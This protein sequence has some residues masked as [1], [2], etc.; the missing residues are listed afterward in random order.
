MDRDEA[1]STLSEL[2]FKGFLSAELNVDG[3]LMIFKTVNEKEFDLIKMY[4]GNP[5]G[6][7]YKARFNVFFLVFSAFILENENILYER[8]KNIPELYNYFLKIPD[9]LF[10]KILSSL[11]SVRFLA[12]ET[13]KFLEGFSYTTMSRNT[14]RALGVTLP[15][16]SSFTGI[17]GSSDLGLNVHQESW[18]SINRSLDYG[19][20]YNRNFSMALLVAS[21]SN[22]KGAR[23]IRNQHDSSKKMAE[24]R[25]KKL[26]VEGF[27]D[28]KKWTPEGWAAPVDTAEG[29]VAE[30]ERQMTGQKDKHDIFMEKYME[31]IRLQAQKKTQEAEERIRK[32]REN[33]DNVLIDGSQRMLTPEETQKLYR[34]KTATTV[35]VASEEATSEEDKGKFYKKIG[36]RILTG[37]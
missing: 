23:H 33:C 30:L 22:P 32:I 17:P 37:K 15:C 28:T 36:T 5:N 10:R 7:D 13:L 8:T 6:R 18:I 24:D 2:I 26:A 16:S 29:L 25:Q 3:K 9:K 35:E 4:A 14:W 34:K 1:Y 12:Y 27:I 11:N 21:S 20:D 19:E 31:N